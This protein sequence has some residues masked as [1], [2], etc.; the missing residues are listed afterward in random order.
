MSVATI[1]ASSDKRSSYPLQVIAFDIDALTLMTFQRGQQITAT[2][3]TEWRSSYTMV[4]KSVES[5]Q[6]P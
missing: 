2:G 4:I 6:T 3:K 1:L 5:F